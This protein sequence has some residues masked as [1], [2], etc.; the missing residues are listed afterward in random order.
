MARMLGNM[1]GRRA[2]HS[3][4]RPGRKPRPALACH[5]RPQ[6]INPAARSHEINRASERRRG[7]RPPNSFQSVRLFFGGFHPLCEALLCGDRWPDFSRQEICVRRLEISAG[8]DQRLQ[9][10]NNARQYPHHHLRGQPS[11]RYIVSFNIYLAPRH[12]NSGY[13]SR[14][15]TSI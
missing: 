5:R 13:P 6:G 10:R 12:L 1:P 9:H 2:S 3:L 8:P 11:A 15:S 14:F 4:N 7:A